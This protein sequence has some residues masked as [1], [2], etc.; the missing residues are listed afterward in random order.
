MKPR[1]V[2]LP[3]HYPRAAMLA[4][5]VSPKQTEQ[6]VP[7]TPTLTP[8]LTPAQRSSMSVEEDDSIE[9]IVDSAAGLAQNEPS[10]AGSHASSHSDPLH[11]PPALLAE[12]ARFDQYATYE[13]VVYTMELHALDAANGHFPISSVGRGWLDANATRIANGDK[14]VLH[15]AA[16]RYLREY[17]EGHHRLPPTG[18]P[19]PASAFGGAGGASLAP[20]AHS[21]SQPAMVEPPQVFNSARPRPRP[22]PLA[23]GQAPAAATTRRV[24]PL[25]VTPND[26]PQAAAVGPRPGRLDSAT[27]TGHYPVAR[28][29]RHDQH[30]YANAMPFSPTTM[31]IYSA[32]HVPVPE[33]DIYNS[34]LGFASPCGAVFPFPPVS[35]A[36]AIDAPMPSPFSPAFCVNGPIPPPFLPVPLP[37][38]DGPGLAPVVDI[39]GFV[40]PSVASPGL[41]LTP[42]LSPS[43]SFTSYGSTAPSTPATPYD[44]VLSPSP[45]TPPCGDVTTT[46]TTTTKLEG[47]G[48]G[49]TPKSVGRLQVEAWL[50]DPAADAVL[51]SCG[52]VKFFDPNKGWGYIV[53]QGHPVLAGQDIWVHYTALRMDRGHRFVVE[54]EWV[55]YTVVWD[56]QKQQ[57]KCLNVQGFGGRPFFAETHP[58]EA[59][60]LAR[61]KPCTGPL[62]STLP[63]DSRREVYA[64]KVEGKKKA[65]MTWLNEVERKNDEVA[66]FVNATTNEQVRIVVEGDVVG[67]GFDDTT[68]ENVKDLRS[69]DS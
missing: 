65:T 62:P 9:I 67:L 42:Q 68:L 12:L 25:R 59:V 54:G 43:S 53:D 30:Q 1:C 26:P 6:P 58:S 15:A 33:F 22:P 5:A 57:L 10:D 19:V 52:M 14:P 36:L 69:V 44:P 37:A 34:P 48:P 51:H 20:V 46:T 23:L 60:V 4:K 45:L 21:Q 63:L 3:S 27:S 24:Q 64:A 39:N 47:G 38:I 41:S 35:P 32:H 49:P 13:D 31:T 11:G 16:R 17:N 28:H 56:A 66:A 18:F 8:P 7:H 61:F 2:S 29:A 50:S 40:V 55:E